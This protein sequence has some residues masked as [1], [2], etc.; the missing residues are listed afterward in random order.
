MVRNLRYV[1]S[2]IGVIILVFGIKPVNDSLKES[3]PVLST[4]PANVLLIIGV[5]VIGIGIFI[6]KPSR[7]GKQSSEVPIYH[8][9]EIVGYRRH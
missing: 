7:R 6:L 8:G 4:V 3:I 2:I 5:V 9:K 1:I